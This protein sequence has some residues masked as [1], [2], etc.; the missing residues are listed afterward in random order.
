MRKHAD[1]I[2]NLLGNFFLRITSKAI[3]NRVGQVLPAEQDKSFQILLARELVDVD[4]SKTIDASAFVE[5]DAP[6]TIEAFLPLLDN[7]GGV[8]SQHM[9]NLEV[10]DALHAIVQVLRQVRG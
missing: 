2:R 6:P 4:F 10:A 8:V 5:L 3:R 1:E 9:N 7:L